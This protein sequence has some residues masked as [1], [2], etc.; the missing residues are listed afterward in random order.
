MEQSVLHYHK[1][2]NVLCIWNCPVTRRKFPHKSFISSPLVYHR[3][4][5]LTLNLYPNDIQFQSIPPANTVY[6]GQAG[7]KITAGKRKYFFFYLWKLQALISRL[8][9]WSAT[10]L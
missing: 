7:I 3:N 8:F 4:K 9:F 1:Q 6:I 10:N 5:S 2:L